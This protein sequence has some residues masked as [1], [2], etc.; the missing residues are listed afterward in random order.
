VHFPLYS[1]SWLNR[2]NLR[3]NLVEL[4]RKHGKLWKVNREQKY[5][6]CISD[7]EWIEYENG[8]ETF[9]FR[10]IRAEGDA[11]YLK[12]KG[13][14][15]FVRIDSNY[16]KYGECPHTL[17][18]CLYSGSWVDGNILNIESS[19]LQ[20][21]ELW[22]AEN[23]EIYFKKESDTHW[24]VYVDGIE[25]NKF[26]YM[27]SEFD[28]VFLKQVD[29][30]IFMRID[31]RSCKKSTNPYKID[32]LCY[33][34]TWINSNV[35]QLSTEPTLTS[36]N[37]NLNSQQNAILNEASS[38]GNENCE[39]TVLTDIN[40]TIVTNDSGNDDDFDSIVDY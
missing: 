29:K 27:K 8:K 7:E 18:K 12:K 34:G 21:C 11:V 10:F 28:A 3:S 37:S 26:K 22:K 9:S 33:H 30:N 32:E 19:D 24:I 25:V 14:L 20:K 38:I 1:G 4:N 2:T 23:L 35:V 17:N 5:F 6:K 36:Y 13:W 39:K 40:K 15:M 16:F 31:S